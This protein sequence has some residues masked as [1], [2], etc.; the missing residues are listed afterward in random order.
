M[1]SRAVFV[2]AVYCSPRLLKHNL[3][4]IQS[5]Y[6]DEPGVSLQPV[7]NKISLFCGGVDVASS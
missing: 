7:Y 4:L 2:A 1:G 6:H 3:N 5:K